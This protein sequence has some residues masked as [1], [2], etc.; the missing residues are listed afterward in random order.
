[1]TQPFK[2]KK[3]KKKA[4]KSQR[5]ICK[6][7]GSC[8]AH[9]VCVND[10]AKPATAGRGTER[11]GDGDSRAGSISCNQIWEVPPILSRA[12]LR[13]ENKFSITTTNKWPELEHY[14]RISVWWMWPSCPL[15]L[16]C[17]SWK[18]CACSDCSSHS[19][20]S[21]QKAQEG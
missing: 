12:G 1:M 10:C 14:S 5:T 8:P 13:V 17:C 11:E 9:L 19:A 15:R 6:F 20:E 16:L 3:K 7:F 21:L 4:L 18:E 2:S